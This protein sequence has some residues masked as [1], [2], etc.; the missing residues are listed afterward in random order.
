MNAQ[1]LYGR[2]LESRPGLPALFVSGYADM[3]GGGEPYQGA[4]SFL[5][6]PF[7]PTELLSILARLTS[8]VASV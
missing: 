2:L 8:G 7:T 1:A 6:K 3:L 5:R 4:V